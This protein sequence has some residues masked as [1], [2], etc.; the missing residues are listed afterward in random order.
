M[1]STSDL[2]SVYHYT[3]MAGLLGIV[4]TGELRATEASGMNDP[5]EVGGGLTRIRSWLELRSD[6]PTARDILENVLPDADPFPALSFVLS[7]SLDR[8]DA[9]QWRLYGDGGDGSCIELD[10]TK[11]LSIRTFTKLLHERD[12]SLK[13]G[14]PKKKALERGVKPPYVRGWFNVASVTPWTLATYEDG[15]VD[16]KLSSLLDEASSEF[17]AASSA[18]PE[19]EE[20]WI[21]AKQ[22]I[23]DQIA[24]LAGTFKGASWVHEREARIVAT[25]IRSNPHSQF[26]SSRYGL[27]QYVRLAEHTA[28]TSHTIARKGTWRVPIKSV[29]LGPR[30]NFDLAAPSVRALLSR[31]GYKSAIDGETYDDM[32]E[33]V[34]VRRSD[35]S[36]R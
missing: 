17:M 22:R 36:L 29:T 13:T 4:S 18:P 12:L 26:R 20:A 19:Y 28:G 14:L 35:A 30:Q 25:L 34:L 16:A 23:L 11:R 5:M 10:A 24:H 9:T 7:A 3:D 1:A 33:R 15:D 6:D 21:D 8:D 27:V 31:Y 32:T 2:A